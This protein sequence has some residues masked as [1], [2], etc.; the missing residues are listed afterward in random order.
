MEILPVPAETTETDDRIEVMPVAAEDPSSPENDD[1]LPIN[2]A[3]ETAVPENPTNATPVAVEDMSPRDSIDLICHE[4]AERLKRKAELDAMVAALG[5]H[6]NG[7]FTGVAL[8][9][10]AKTF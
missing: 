2:T 5:I 3:I 6:V 9:V 7:E 4:L 1:I 10:Q 8:K